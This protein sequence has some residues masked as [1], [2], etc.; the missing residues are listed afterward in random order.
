MVL[1]QMRAHSG[2][3]VT[4]SLLMGARGDLPDKTFVGEHAPS[5]S[6]TA[7]NTAKSL[8]F[9]NNEDVASNECSQKKKP[10]A[11]LV[12]PSSSEKGSTNSK[13]GRV[14]IQSPAKSGKMLTTHC[15]MFQGKVCFRRIAGIA[16]W[17]L[18]LCHC[19]VMARKQLMLFS[20]VQ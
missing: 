11:C 16:D 18:I 12:E 2:D 17:E 6:I 4:S 7:G 1:N 5:S 20:P 14:P 8:K 10:R 13:A 19:H 9:C 3:D 15:I